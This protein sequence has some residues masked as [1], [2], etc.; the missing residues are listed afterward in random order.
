MKHRRRMILAAA[1][2]VAA[3]R[4]LLAQQPG[5]IHYV[6]IL[7]IGTDPDLQDSRWK[8]FTDAMRELGYAEGRNLRVVHAHG[9]GIGEKLP[10]LIKAVLNAK[11]DVIVTTGRREIRALQRATSTVP[12]VMTFA[13]DPVEDGFV[14]SLARPGG[15]IT[16]LTYLVPGMHQK[17]IE[18]LRELVPSAKKFAVISMP[19]NPVPSEI[20]D[21]DAA[22]RALGVSVVV[23]QPAKAEEFDGTLAR[24]KKEGV[25]GIVVPLDGGA[26]RYRS[27]LIPL[28]QA[29]RLPAIYGDRIFVDSGGLVSYAAS[30]ADNYRRAATFVDK[31]LRGASPAELPVE[32]PRKF[33]L[34][35]NMKVAKALNLKIPPTFLLRA[36][37]VIE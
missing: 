7:S 17:Y 35:I 31:I 5:K 19:P 33:Y 10:D 32:Q 16:G 9:K 22:A 13:H 24:L 23:A 8:P 18:L 14:Q 20:R 25:A 34:V 15:N 30:F 4:S 3:P 12:I 37:Q 2:A 27:M 28:A 36:D 11:V 26:V 6:G 21:I 29:H 1:A